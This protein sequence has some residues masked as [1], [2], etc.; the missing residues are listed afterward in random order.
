MRIE[1]YCLLK[2][3]KIMEDE[4][5]KDFEEMFLITDLQGKKCIK[6]SEKFCN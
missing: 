6:A 5:C 4:D 1:S 3:R 2:L